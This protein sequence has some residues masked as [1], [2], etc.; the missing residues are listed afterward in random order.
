MTWLTY[1]DVFHQINMEP[2]LGLYDLLV[3]MQILIIFTSS[4]TTEF[5]ITYSR[6]VSII[7]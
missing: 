7:F 1:L 5:R 6:V 4:L 2:L 3:I